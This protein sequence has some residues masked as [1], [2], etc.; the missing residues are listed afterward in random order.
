MLYGS[1]G[2]PPRN[3]AKPPNSDFFRPL[4]DAGA[5]GSGC[6]EGF[7]GSG[8]AALVSGT[9]VG[10]ER[11]LSKTGC[12]STSPQPTHWKVRSSKPGISIWWGST[13]T[14][15][16]GSPQIKHCIGRHHPAK[17]TPRPPY[18]TAGTLAPHRRSSHAQTNYGPVTCNLS[19]A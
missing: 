10:R 3:F 14:T 9:S 7:A 4:G 8:A 11:S 2:L 5:T 6:P 15:R 16:I 13:A 17:L 12:F 1:A 19:P 18:Q